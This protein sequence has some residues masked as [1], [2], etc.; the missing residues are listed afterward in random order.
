VEG[1]VA[2]VAHGVEHTVKVEKNGW[3]AKNQCETYRRINGGQW[4]VLQEKNAYLSLT[5]K[6][7]KKCSI[8]REVN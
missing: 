6:D 1:L 8:K 4:K 5:S 2:R 3:K 7:R